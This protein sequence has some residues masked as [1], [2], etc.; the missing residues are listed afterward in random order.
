MS[1]RHLAMVAILVPDYDAGIDFFVGQLGFDL[2]EDTDLGD[3]KRWVRVAPEGAQ[4][5]F[6]LARA[7]GDQRD[8]IGRQG[9]GRVW[10]FLETDDFDRDHRAMLAAG[11][12]FEEAPRSAPYGKVAVFNDPFGNRW[13]LIEFSRDPD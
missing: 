1:N 9:G 3:G 2:L 7:I 4:T 12:T 6:L 5:Q 11:I 8:S 13:D 10:L